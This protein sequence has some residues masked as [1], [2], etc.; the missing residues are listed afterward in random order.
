MGIQTSLDNL[1]INQPVT[2]QSSNYTATLKDVTI[3]YTSTAA[4]YMV[5]IPAATSGAT[6]GKLYRIVDASGGAGTNNIIVAPE[7]GTIDSIGSVSINENYGSIALYSDGSQWYS[8]SSN[9]G[10]FSKTAAYAAWDSFNS[11][12]FTPGTTTIDTTTTAWNSTVAP[13]SARLDF[14]ALTNTA[15]QG[16]TTGQYAQTINQSDVYWVKVVAS[17]DGSA[18][19]TCVVQIVKNTTTV[20]AAGVSTITAALDNV[21]FSAEGLFS[22]SANDTLDFRFI[23]LSTSYSFY[24]IEVTIQQVSFANTNSPYS[25]T[26]T[27]A[28]QTF[29]ATGTYNPSANMLYSLVEVIGSGGAGGGPSTSGTANSVASG[30]GGGAGG[31]AKAT[32]SATQIGPSVAVTI[33]AAGTGSA[34]AAG[35]NGASC[36]FGTF[37]SATGGQGGSADVASAATAVSTSGGA[38]GAGSLDDPTVP[39]FTAT[40][41][42]GGFGFAIND[43]SAT[44]G[45]GGAGGNSVYD[46]CGAGLGGTNSA[47]NNGSSFGAGGGGGAL[48]VTSS[49]VA[50]G[51]G[52]SGAVIV[53]EFLF[54][55][56]PLS[57][58]TSI[59]GWRFIS[60]TS[61][62]MASSYG[63]VPTSS[64]L[65]TFTLPVSPTVRTEIAVQGSGSGG[66]TIA[67]NAGQQILFG[68]QTTTT[69][70]A[71]SLAST[72]QYDSVTLLVL[73]STSFIVLESLGNITVT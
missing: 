12:S 42:A 5:T 71:G 39:G 26:P 6:K 44:A 45:G 66:W 55:S 61:Q 21:P 25:Y 57:T 58:N 48:T 65:T 50:G 51:N 16:I 1:F 23:G 40:G 41:G 73:S 11:T 33:G 49:S 67:Q 13:D 59:F 4:S 10:V 46:G 37:L 3:E 9:L 69:G 36:S 43:A 29:T 52:S 53:T 64:S 7:L 31:Y 68:T 24:Q 17:P 14:T 20:L 34:G 35:G 54:S 38:G 28:I 63:Y 2:R 72:N 56:T 47:G 18:N 19:S 15:L 30:G 32:L 70:T 27:Q 22:L 60:S 8:R 62:R